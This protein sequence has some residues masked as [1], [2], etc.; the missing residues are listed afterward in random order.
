MAEDKEHRSPTPG[1]ASTSPNRVG[2][3]MDAFLHFVEGYRQGNASDVAN[4]ELK[5]DHSLRVLE[6]AEMIAASLDATSG[7][8]APSPSTDEVDLWLT[9]AL[10][11]DLG[12]FPQ[13]AQYKTFHDGKS[14][15]HAVLG[16]K[17]LRSHQ[18]LADL[19]KESRSVVLSAILLHNKHT[20]PR[21]LPPRIQCAASIVRDGDKLDIMR[22]MQEHFAREEPNPVV[23]LHLKEH[24][25]AYSEEIYAQVMDGRLAEY[26]RMRWTNDFKLLLCSWVYD[27]NFPATRR[28][29]DERG[30]LGAL[31]D[32]LPCTDPM[33]RLKT[34]VYET[35]RADES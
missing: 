2:H 22:V 20:L 12:R 18:L 4:V 5:R 33:R 15:N 19:S 25:T 26:R 21:G 24:P 28:A 8:S 34:R 13:Y 27:L 7:D 23:T 32:S 6:N 1:A 31:L 14:K 16:V 35:L 3:Y 30:H 29:M 9:A 17:A 10:F 11:H